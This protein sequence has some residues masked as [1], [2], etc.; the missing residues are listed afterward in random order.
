MNPNDH[1]VVL[2]PWEVLADVHVAQEIQIV[3]G[4]QWHL[5]AQGAQIGVVTSSSARLSAKPKGR[6]QLLEGDCLKAAKLT[7]EV[8][9]WWRYWRHMLMLSSS[10][11]QTMS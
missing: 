4:P 11:R 8:I 7:S 3:E 1:E 2:Q 9:G 6:R 10:M 5:E